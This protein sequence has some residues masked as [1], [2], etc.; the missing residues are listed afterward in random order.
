M[1]YQIKNISLLLYID[2]LIKFLFKKFIIDFKTFKKK[3]NQKIY[4][5][6][7]PVKSIKVNELEKKIK[8]LNMQGKIFIYQI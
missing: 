4:K 8:F 5:S 2:D 7:S 3:N 1:F 6:F